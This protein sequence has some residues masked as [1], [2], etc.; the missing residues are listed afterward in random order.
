MGP[1]R[2]YIT[3][4]SPRPRRGLSP[5]LTYRGSPSEMRGPVIEDE[6]DLDDVLR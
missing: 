1:E 6:P 3:R 4:R 5:D 2:E